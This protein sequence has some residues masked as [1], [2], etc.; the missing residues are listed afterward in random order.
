MALATLATLADKE[1]DDSKLEVEAASI[2]A[3]EQ[4][5]EAAQSARTTEERAKEAADGGP[6]SR[7]CLRRTLRSVP[8]RQKRKFSSTRVCR[9]AFDR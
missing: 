2:L 3:A 9:I 6:R 7:I 5:L 1:T 8:H 4:A